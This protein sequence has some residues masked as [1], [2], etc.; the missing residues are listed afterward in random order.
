[1]DMGTHGELAVESRVDVVALAAVVHDLVAGG[2]SRLQ[3]GR[4]LRERAVAVGLDRHERGALEALRARLLDDGAA[5]LRAPLPL[6]P[7]G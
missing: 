3:D 7:W 1:M 5:L 2:F 4:W 6:S